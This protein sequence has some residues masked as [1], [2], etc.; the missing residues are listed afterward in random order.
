MKQKNLINAHCGDKMIVMRKKYKLSQSEVAGAIGLTRTSVVNIEKGRQSLTVECLLK[1][2][3]LFKCKP[4]DILP[5]IPVAE[6]K[7][8]IKE[9]NQSLP[10][11]TI[12]ATFK[13]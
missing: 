2:C 12:E 9:Q 5:S 3:S 11:K 7:K 10:Y 8:V 1:A 4:A 13:W 6:F